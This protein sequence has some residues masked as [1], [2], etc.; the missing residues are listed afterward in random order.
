MSHVSN[1]FDIGFKPKPPSTIPAEYRKIYM[2]E[3]KTAAIDFLVSLNMP[4]EKLHKF[5]KDIIDGKL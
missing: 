5:M 3:G 4:K 2:S 1:V